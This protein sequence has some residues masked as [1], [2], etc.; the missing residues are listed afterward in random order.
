[1]RASAWVIIQDPAHFFQ[2]KGSP[3]R[4]LGVAQTRWAGS[5]RVQHT[6]KRL[7]LK[8]HVVLQDVEN[9]IAVYFPQHQNSIC[10]KTA[11][12]DNKYVNEWF[13]GW[14]ITSCL[15]F[16]T[17]LLITSSAILNNPLPLSIPALLSGIYN[18]MTSLLLLLLLHLWLFI[19]CGT[20]WPSWTG[21]R[22]RCVRH[23]RN[24]P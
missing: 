10:F 21:Y 9:G 5:L 16:V 12:Y 8:Q 3:V 22:W 18:P 17:V 11:Y 24:F 13:V 23:R 15:C 2:S 20:W 4:K 6:H 7:H 19:L 1:M 14:T